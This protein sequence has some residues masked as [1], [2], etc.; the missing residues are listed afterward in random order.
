MQVIFTLNPCHLFL[1]VGLQM[2]MA[3]TASMGLIPIPSS[4]PRATHAHELAVLSGQ[5]SLSLSS[6]CHLAL[7]AQSA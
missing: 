1:L 4:S 7:C 2:A 3:P 5:K 6:S